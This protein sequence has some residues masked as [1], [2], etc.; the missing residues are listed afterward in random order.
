MCLTDAQRSS[1]LK[2]VRLTILASIRGPISSAPG[3]PCAS[4]I[5]GATGMNIT[6]AIV[7]DGR[8]PAKLATQP[9]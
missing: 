6:L 9:Q 2:P 4:D 3:A 8:D 5:Q 7:G 1:D